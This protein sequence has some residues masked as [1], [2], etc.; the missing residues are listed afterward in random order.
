MLIAERD[1]EDP[2]YYFSI[3]E[4]KNVWTE[5]RGR[6]SHSSTYRKHKTAHHG[7]GLHI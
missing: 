7:T 1:D 6:N 3:D 5:K 4:T 2:I